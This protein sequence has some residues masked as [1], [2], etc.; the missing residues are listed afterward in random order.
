MTPL[1][2]PFALAIALVVASLVYLFIGFSTYRADT[3]SPLRKA[4]MATCFSLSLWSGFY[5]LMTIAGDPFRMWVFWVGGYLSMSLFFPS[6]LHFHCCLTGWRVARQKA[7]I[8]FSYVSCG[9]VGLAS[10]IWGRVQFVATGWGNQFIYHGWLFKAAS[11]YFCLVVLFTYTEVWWRKNAVIRRQRAQ[12]TVFLVTTLIAVP[13]GV[14]LIFAVPAFWHQAVAP[15]GPIGLLLVSLV[16]YRTLRV[17]RGLNI[18]VE[19]AAND[20]FKTVTMPILLLDA[21]N[22][23]IQAN[24][25]ALALWQADKDEVVCKNATQ[26]IPGAGEGA[27]AASAPSQIVEIPTPAGPRLCDMMLTISPDAYGDVVDKVVVLRDMTDMQHALEQANAGSRAKSEFLSRMSHEIRTPLN[28]IIGMMHI[29]QKAVAADQKGKAQESVNGAIMASK[30]LLGIINDVLDMSKIEAGKFEVFNEPFSL[31]A[32]MLEV[33]S[34]I[35]SRCREKN[36]VLFQNI[37]TLPD[38]WLRGDKLRLN[39]VLINILGNSVKFTGHGGFITMTVEAR[40]EAGR[41]ALSFALSDSGI[42][43][44]REFLARVFDPFEQAETS[45]HSGGTGLGLPISKT[46]VGL[47]G[48]S[49]TVESEPGRGT[50][51]YFDISLDIVPEPQAEEPEYCCGYDFTGKRILLAEDIVVNRVILAELL[52]ETNVVIDEAENGRRA[53]EIFAA[54]PPWYYDL[55][56]MDIQMPLMD[57]YEATKNIRALQRPDAKDVP[58]VAMTA[59]AYKEDVANALRAGMNDHLS[60]PIDMDVVMRTL[61]F[62]FAHRDAAEGR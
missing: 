14:W 59:N 26:L 19:N 24:D 23:V 10:V 47:M 44:S 62:H 30:H 5:G 3:K 15:V 40:E 43:M 6:W 37:S 1:N 42:G 9:V 21:Q 52:A 2:L 27:F 4:Y 34:V 55:V 25:A 57:G 48:G 36:Q 29:A 46:L 41:M 38:V 45:R 20:I 60:K 17:N 49:I 18:T 12:A 56:L 39:Q 32:A 8:L 22:T 16:F 33:E 50:S 51:F 7:L 28:A 61:A 11:L 31:R 54:A 53:V 35:A 58:I 13:P